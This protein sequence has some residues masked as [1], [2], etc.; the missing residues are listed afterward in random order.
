MIGDLLAREVT[1]P[2]GSVPPPL[3]N[4][5][6]QPSVSCPVD[7]QEHDWRSI[8]RRDLR[9]DQQREPDRLGSDMCPNDSRQ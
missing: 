1:L 2:L 8:D 6:R 5:C 4:Q 9:P 3:G 7:R